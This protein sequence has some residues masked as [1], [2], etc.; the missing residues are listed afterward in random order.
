MLFRSA[1]RGSISLDG[2]MSYTNV[3][4]AFSGGVGSDLI[5]SICKY[6]NNKYKDYKCNQIIAGDESIVDIQTDS[7]VSSLIT[8]NFEN[9]Y[10]L[11]IGQSSISYA[12][13]AVRYYTSQKDANYILAGE[14]EMIDRVKQNTILSF[15]HTIAL[16]KQKYT[17]VRVYDCW[18]KIGQEKDGDALV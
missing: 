3:N 5:K 1:G 15:L 4:L 10:N 11:Y 16:T 6:I 12:P 8:K 9:G 17:G 14:K 13:V 7:V 18:L 2:G